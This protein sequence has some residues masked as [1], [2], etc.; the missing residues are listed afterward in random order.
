MKDRLIYEEWLLKYKGILCA[1]DFSLVPASNNIN[2]EMLGVCSID[3]SEELKILFSTNIG[4]WFKR[5]TFIERDGNRM[6][7]LYVVTIERR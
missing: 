7:M 3:Y 2:L 1:P 5:I 6:Q 4:V